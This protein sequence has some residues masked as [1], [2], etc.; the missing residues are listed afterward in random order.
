MMIVTF[1]TAS[2]ACVPHVVAPIIMMVFS[3]YKEKYKW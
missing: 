2:S 3:G 1:F